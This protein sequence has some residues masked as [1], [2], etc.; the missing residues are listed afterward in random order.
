MYKYTAKYTD[1]DDVER[2]EDLYF[3]LSKAE[4]MRME[5]SQYGGMEAL[6][7]KIVKEQD[8]KRIYNMFE[9]IVQSSYG[10]KSDDGRRFIK[11][12]EV[13]DNFIQTE[14]YSELI[15]KMLNDPDFANEFIK[16]IFPKD[17]SAELDKQENV[18]PKK[19]NNPIPAPPEK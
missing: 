3:N 12:P 1:Y 6:L 16:G 9:E 13:L 17:I 19:V 15:M 10:V 7:K 11:N 8:T 18:L 2:E 4:L 5:M 14:A